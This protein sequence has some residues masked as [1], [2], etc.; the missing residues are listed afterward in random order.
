MSGYHEVMN[1]LLFAQSVKA[2]IGI[3]HARGIIMARPEKYTVDYFPHLCK[4]GKTMFIIE[5]HYGNDGYAFWFKLLEL[6]AT[7]HGHYFDA[8]NPLQMEFLAAKTRLSSSQTTDLLCL[9]AQIEAIDKDL[10][11]QRRVIWCQNL[12]NNVAEVYENRKGLLPEK[13]YFD[14]VKLSQNIDNHQFNIVTDTHN[15]QSKV[16]YSKVKESKV[17]I[18]KKP[19]GEFSNVQL[20]D[21]EYK[22]LLEKFGDVGTKDRIEKLSSGIESHGYKYKSHYATILSWDRMDEKN[23]RKAQPR[24]SGNQ[25]SYNQKQRPVSS[26]PIPRPEDYTDPENL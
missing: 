4:Q 1:T 19:Y 13:P 2:P 3:N 7:S 22:K 16:K 11:E 6:L 26:R 8:N 23:G 5:S 25:T 10:W 24:I 14:G 12:I 20:S 15:T 17:D 9:L 18:A 21:E